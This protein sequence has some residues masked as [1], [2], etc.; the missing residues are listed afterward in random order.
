MLNT[1]L[2]ITLSVSDHYS[3]IPPS[4]HIANTH[5]RVGLRCCLLENVH[6]R[7]IRTL[8][9]RKGEA[10][11]GCS[12]ATIYNGVTGSEMRAHIEAS[13]EGVGVQLDDDCVHCSWVYDFR[14][15]DILEKT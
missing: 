8:N 1:S 5:I 7:E 14:H 2:C 13:Q 11:V 6:V 9:R 15:D 3:T 4:L 12:R 10:I